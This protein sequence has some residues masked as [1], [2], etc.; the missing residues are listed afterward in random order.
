MIAWRHL[1]ASLPTVVVYGGR[2]RRRFTFFWADSQQTG[3]ARGGSPVSL[4]FFLSISRSQTQPPPTPP[5]PS[6]YTG[7]SVPRMVTA[8]LWYSH[9]SAAAAESSTKAPDLVPRWHHTAALV[10]QYPRAPKYLRFASVRRLVMCVV[11]GRHHQQNSTGDTTFGTCGRDAP[12][13]Y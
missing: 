6:H 8:A 4:S 10:P 2:R 7:N 12:L 5:P 11:N 1:K 9:D 13:H 3:T